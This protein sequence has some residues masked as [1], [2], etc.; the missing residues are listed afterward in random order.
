MPQS[1]RVGPATGGVAKRTQHLSRVLQ[2]LFGFACVDRVTRSSG[3][4]SIVQA[5]RL[6]VQLCSYCALR[7]MLPASM[8]RPVCSTSPPEVD[9][10]CT[11]PVPMC[12]GPERESAEQAEQLISDSVARPLST[13]LP[14]RPSGRSRPAFRQ[15]FLSARVTGSTMP[16]RP[17]EGAPLALD[18]PELVQLA[19]SSRRPAGVETAAAR[20]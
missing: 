2:G 17:A 20:R 4:A 6:F 13:G 14:R 11:A 12:R 19:R 8:W 3:A 15:L 9:L 18:A 1:S 7:H 5:I 16:V 10:A